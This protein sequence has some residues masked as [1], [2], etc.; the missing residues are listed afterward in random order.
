MNVETG[1]IKPLHEHLR[2]CTT[3]EQ[4]EAMMKKLL[5]VGT[6]KERAEHILD[7]HENILKEENRV[8]RNRRKSSKR[9]GLRTSN[10]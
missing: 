1:E 6:T 10:R 4:K 5:P 8:L 3:K 9:K 2:G 7:V